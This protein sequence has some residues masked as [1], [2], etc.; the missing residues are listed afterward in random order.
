MLD[1]RAIKAGQRVTVHYVSPVTWARKTD[2]PF[3]DVEVTKES[4]VAFTAAGA[5]TYENQMERQGKEMSGKPCWHRAA[6]EIGAC[7]R[8]HREKG[9]AY[10]AGV[11]HDSNGSQYLISGRP[12]TSDE[13]TEIRAWLKVSPE[14][15]RGIDFRLWTL[16]KLQNAVLV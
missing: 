16:E 6:P 1:I 11:N 5:E 14:T 8:V 12:A 4:S 7:V 2:N 10:L 15:D 13:V 3:L 9:T